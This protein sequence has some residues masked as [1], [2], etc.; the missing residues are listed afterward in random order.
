MNTSRR[1]ASPAIPPS[2]GATTIAAVCTEANKPIARPSFSGGVSTASAASSSGVV[3][4]FATPCS[5]RITSSTPKPVVNA[6]TT[7][8]AAYAM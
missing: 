8:T 3:N 1:S 6:A 7:D 4:A 2:S 5:A